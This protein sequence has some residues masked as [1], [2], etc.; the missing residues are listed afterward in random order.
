[1]NNNQA[2]DL[3]NKIKV[4]G[5]FSV[6]VNNLDEP[7]RGFA[8]SLQG[9][10]EVYNANVL[11]D[12]TILDYIARHKDTLKRHNAYFGAWQDGS[13]IYLD[14]SI[15]V[16][17]R[18]AALQLAAKNNQL[19]IYDITRDESIYLEELQPIREREA[20]YI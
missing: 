15:I 13:R 8:V 9:Y 20:A 17:S 11:D 14:V 1:M 4:N 5:G 7:V 19:A 12:S 3:L 2:K 10:E 16:K 18:A 6:K